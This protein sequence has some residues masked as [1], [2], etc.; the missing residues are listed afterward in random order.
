M[1]LIT[2]RNAV[3]ATLLGFE[4]RARP[5]SET[6]KMWTGSHTNGWYWQAVGEA[7]QTAMVDGIAEGINYFRNLADVAEGVAQRKNHATIADFFGPSRFSIGDTVKEISLLYGEP[8][9]L[10]IPI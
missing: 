10:P 1:R 5:I 4:L 8:A 3:F 7:G 9:N 2:R 6:S